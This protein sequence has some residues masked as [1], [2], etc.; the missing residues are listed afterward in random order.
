MRREYIQK[1]DEYSI[2]PQEAIQ[3]VV[4]YR[5]E[6]N[7]VFIAIDPFNS[8][9]FILNEGNTFSPF[10]TYVGN[11]ETQLL[12]SNLLVNQNLNDGRRDDQLEMAKISTW[13]HSKLDIEGI[14]EKYERGGFSYDNFSF[15]RD[16]SQG[17]WTSDRRVSQDQRQNDV[18]VFNPFLKHQNSHFLIQ[19]QSVVLNVKPNKNKEV[20]QFYYVTNE[21][22][23]M[24]VYPNYQNQE[25][26]SAV[27]LQISKTHQY[28][29]K[30][31]EEYNYEEDFQLR[32]RDFRSQAYKKIAHICN[33]E[34]RNAS[35]I[36]KSEHL[37]SILQY[38]RKLN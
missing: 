9:H 28:N 36:K 1:Q 14:N 12:L 24:L 21:N 10:T 3:T 32:R 31:Q 18:A 11:N 17:R 22:E 20:T 34:Y 5:T 27:L 6:D 30:F 15:G 33:D 4:H 38:E 37:R 8:H 29:R 2:A 26:K 25:Q 13:R 35:Y 23:Y 19:K 16:S 7:L